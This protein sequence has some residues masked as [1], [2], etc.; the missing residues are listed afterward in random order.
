LRAFHCG[1]DLGRVCAARQKTGRW[2]GVVSELR[3]SHRT[4]TGLGDQSAGPELEVVAHGDHEGRL[5]RHRHQRRRPIL[6]DL[7]LLIGVHLPG[8][9]RNRIKFKSSEERSRPRSTPLHWW[10]TSEPGRNHQQGVGKIG[11]APCAG[12]GLPD[13]PPKKPPN[14]FAGRYPLPAEEVLDALPTKRCQ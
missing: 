10:P 11:R 13:A 8:N 2:P 1:L 12:V 5:P 3:G 7:R 4:V 6:V 9:M 14:R